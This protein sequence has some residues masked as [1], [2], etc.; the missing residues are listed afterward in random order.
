MVAVMVLSLS[1]LPV[2]ASCNLPSLWKGIEH[3]FSKYIVLGIKKQKKKHFRVL[4]QKGMI[5]ISHYVFKYLY[6]F[7][8]IALGRG[9]WLYRYKINLILHSDKDYSNSLTMHS[10]RRKAGRWEYSIQL[11]MT[12]VLD[13]QK[14]IIGWNATLPPDQNCCLLTKSS[15]TRILKNACHWLTLLPSEPL[16]LQ[17]KSNPASAENLKKKIK[18]IL[19]LMLTWKWLLWQPFVQ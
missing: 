13:S 18:K 17:W 10:S 8:N 19:L 7:Y 2:N 6:A 11:K 9:F 3:G 5:S 14:V 4:L 16:W 12:G 15:L 1:S